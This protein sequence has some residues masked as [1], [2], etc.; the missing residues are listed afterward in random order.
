MSNQT[1]LRKSSVD[2][3]EL[4]R[5]G[6]YR[7]LAR[8]LARTPD[9]EL[10]TTLAGL[11]GDS[12]EMGQAIS[13]LAAAAAACDAEAARDE[14]QRLFVGLGRGLLVP[15]GSYY[16]TGFLNEK[17]LARL[18]ADMVPLGAARSD[19]SSEPED[20]I[21]SLMEMMA[22]FIDGSFGLSQPLSV[23]AE[24]FNKHVAS[25]ASYFFADLEACPQAQLYA[26][27]GRMGRLFMA[28]EAAAFE[29]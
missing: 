21:A 28:I 1:V 2:E 4:L 12:T 17:P 22:S 23:Q 3:S 16:L 29:M 25:W 18:R 8:L 26:P 13:A 11:D 20:H 15:Y 24:F 27:A 5:S 9:T 10:L 7:L 14:Y 19:G 6:L